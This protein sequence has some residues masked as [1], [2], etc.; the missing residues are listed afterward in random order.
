MVWRAKFPPLWSARGVDIGALKTQFGMRSY[1]A[2]LATTQR[3][4]VAYDF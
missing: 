3:C 2:G 4:G 1:P